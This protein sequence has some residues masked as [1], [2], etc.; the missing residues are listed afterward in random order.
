MDNDESGRRRRNLRSRL[1]C[2]TL[3]ASLSFEHFY[4][5]LLVDISQVPSFFS[6]TPG[7]RH[8]LSNIFPSSD[9]FILYSLFSHPHQNNSFRESLS[10]PSWFLEISKWIKA[11]F[12]YLALWTG[13]H[14]YTSKYL[15]HLQKKKKRAEE[16]REE[17]IYITTY[18]FFFFVPFY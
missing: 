5:N 9:L 11:P 3:G 17:K 15:K 1:K 18:S 6:L 12:V 13:V 14:L 8:L 4:L 10:S 7:F 16:K 2:N